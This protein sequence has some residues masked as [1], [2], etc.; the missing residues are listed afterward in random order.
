MHDPE[1]IEMRNKFLIT[2]L[3]VGIFATTLI[4]FLFKLIGTNSNV[5]SSINANKDV[6][7][8]VVDNKCDKCNAVKEVLKENNVKYKVLNRYKDNKTKLIYQKIGL[9]DEIT[10]P[11]LLNIKKGKLDSYLDNIDDQIVLEEYLESLSR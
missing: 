4:V 9:D 5:S 8:L 11:C 6:L 3:I 1:F 7:I 10:S 2:L